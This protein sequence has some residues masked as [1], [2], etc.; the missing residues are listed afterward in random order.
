M[1]QV[2]Q[3]INQLHPFA[4]PYHLNKR[5]SAQSEIYK[6][7]LSKAEGYL[8]VKDFLERIDYRDVNLL[9]TQSIQISPGKR[10][11][12]K[13]AVCHAGFVWVP[14]ALFHGSMFI[15]TDSNKNLS[16]QFWNWISGKNSPW[17]SVLQGIEPV[18]HHKSGKRTG[19]IIDPHEAGIHDSKKFIFLKN[20]AIACRM[21]NEKEHKIR[22]W[23]DAVSYGLNETEAFYLC[24]F[25]GKDDSNQISAFDDTVTGHWPLN[26]TS[27]KGFR[28]HNPYYSDTRIN[29]CWGTGKS[30]KASNNLGVERKTR[31]SKVREIKM[32][33]CI[34][35]FNEWKK[36][37]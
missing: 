11:V 15:E 28:D 17:K 35:H 37:L 4:V 33:D 1:I 36:T 2:E 20:F 19:W 24:S 27:Y 22:F 23:S 5:S 12:L 29:Q 13:D 3:P 7:K 10:V 34:N 26:S 30:Y 6:G 25:Y 16:E 8:I 21:L 9:Y 18:F 32:S 14:D 31:F